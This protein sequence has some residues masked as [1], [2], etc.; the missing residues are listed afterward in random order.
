MKTLLDTAVEVDIVR[1]AHMSLCEVFW[2]LL[3]L[4]LEGSYLFSLLFPL[5]FWCV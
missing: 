4:C 2:M 1:S 5:Y 3:L